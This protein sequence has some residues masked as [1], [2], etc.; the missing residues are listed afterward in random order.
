MNPALIKQVAKETG[1]KVAGPLYSDSIGT[2]DS[3]ASTFLG[4]V[5]ENT[6]MITEALG[7]K[8][9]AFTMNTDEA[10]Q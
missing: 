7:G 2:A 6:R 5:R 8:H 10:A 3:P 1:V 4:T 9:V